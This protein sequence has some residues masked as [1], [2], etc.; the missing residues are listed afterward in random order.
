M[1]RSLGAFAEESIGV[2]QA[3]FERESTR[4]PAAHAGAG[5]LRSEMMPLRKNR[6]AMIKNGRLKPGAPASKDVAEE[7]RG[8]E[9]K[10]AG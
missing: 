9:S 3:E 6:G 8:V 1:S 7:S 2:D 10:T 4:L 5:E